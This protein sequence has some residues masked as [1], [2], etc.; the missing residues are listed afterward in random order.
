MD[1]AK[2]GRKQRRAERHKSSSAA[3]YLNLI[4]AWKQGERTE[5]EVSEDHQ[6]QQQQ[7]QKHNQDRDKVPD[8]DDVH[9]NKRQKRHAT[10]NLDHNDNNGIT[11]DAPNNDNNNNNS[12]NQGSEGDYLLGF[13]VLGGGELLANSAKTTQQGL[14]AQPY[15]PQWMM[16][17][18]RNIDDSNFN[19]S[20]DWF[21]ENSYLHPIL[22]KNLKEEMGISHFLPVQVH[23]K[24]A[25]TIE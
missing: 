20:V 25:Y 6:Q 5:F 18:R 22:V 14:R 17:G 10:T 2:K 3:R 21:Q 7:K 16:K 12:T 9:V 11:E 15:A 8:H 1:Q 4:E 19:V 24:C 13:K 23:N